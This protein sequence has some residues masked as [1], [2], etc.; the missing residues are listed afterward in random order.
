MQKKI[1]CMLNSY[2]S[3]STHKPLLDDSYD[4]HYLSSAIHENHFKK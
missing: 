4:K 2:M 1:I 3:F